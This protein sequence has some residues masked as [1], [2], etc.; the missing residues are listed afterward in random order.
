MRFSYNTFKSYH[1][2]TKE[3]PF[4][5]KLNNFNLPQILFIK[6]SVKNIKKKTHIMQKPINSLLLL[7]SKIL[8]TIKITKY[9]LNNTKNN[10][11]L[12]CD[13]R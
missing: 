1:I 5:A 7:E 6:K 2:R 8:K 13:C 10:I 3:T 11:V 12:V 9:I 4:L